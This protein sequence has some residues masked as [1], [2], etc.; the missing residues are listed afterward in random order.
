MLYSLDIRS[1]HYTL[2]MPY[3]THVH[4]YHVFDEYREKF[5]CLTL[6]GEPPLSITLYVQ[7]HHSSEYSPVRT[8]HPSQVP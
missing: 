1:E 2:S 4:A 6:N 7:K 5:S 3:D 8:Y